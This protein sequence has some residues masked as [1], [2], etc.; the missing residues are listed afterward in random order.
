MNRRDFL[1]GVPAVALGAALVSLPVITDTRWQR[2]TKLRIGE[3][4]ELRSHRDGETIYSYVYK[5]SQGSYYPLA[6]TGNRVQRWMEPLL[7]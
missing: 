7:A 4:I 6:A 3:I 1:K 2:V 5:N